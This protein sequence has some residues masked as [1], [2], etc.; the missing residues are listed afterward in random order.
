LGISTTS[1]SFWTTSLSLWISLL[2]DLY[3][4]LSLPSFSS[5]STRSLLSSLQREGE[6]AR[7]IRWVTL[8]NW[9]S[10]ALWAASTAESPAPTMHMAFPWYWEG[11]ESLKQTLSRSSFGSPSFLGDPPTP[12]A[13]MTFWALITPAEV[14]ASRIFPF[15]F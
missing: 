7:T 11:S 8:L 13:R 10:A 3:Q 15:T 4:I 9:G 6:S 12:T 2:A 14:S 5:L 1:L